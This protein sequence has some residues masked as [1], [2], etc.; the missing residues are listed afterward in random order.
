MT[1]FQCLN[2]E[3]NLDYQ[4]FTGLF[5][6]LGSTFACCRVW[7]T[8]QLPKTVAS[9]ENA[10]G[11]IQIPASVDLQPLVGHH[12][13]LTFLE[14]RTVVP[15]GILQYH[16][17]HADVDSITKSHALIQ[18]TAHGSLLYAYSTIWLE[19][20]YSDHTVFKISA[21]IR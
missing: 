16:H 3:P 7:Y 10:P 17:P 5:Q 4:Q 6:R 12:P 2:L 20:R 14:M 13:V 1:T 9:C 11:L 18:N 8:Y 19:K 15:S 21:S